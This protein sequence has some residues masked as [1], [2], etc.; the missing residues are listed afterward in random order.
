MT[1]DVR[2]CIHSCSKTRAHM[3]IET[4]RS[5]STN[6]IGDTDS[7]ILAK[8]AAELILYVRHGHGAHP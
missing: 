4:E 2:L 6:L 5:F 3:T 8:K 7:C 1:D